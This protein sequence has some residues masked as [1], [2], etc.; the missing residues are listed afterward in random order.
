[1]CSSKACRHSYVV[2]GTP[3]VFA[4]AQHT[5]PAH[6]SCCSSNSSF[7]NPRPTCTQPAHLQQRRH[8]L[9]RVSGR[10]RSDAAHQGACCQRNQLLSIAA[11]LLI[12]ADCRMGWEA[13]KQGGEEGKRAWSLLA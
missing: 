4:Q 8:E 10:R 9:A 12:Q 2:E 6:A 5:S 11:L 7:P 13:G 1:M 3:A